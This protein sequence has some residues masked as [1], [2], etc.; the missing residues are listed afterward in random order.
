MRVPVT[1]AF[2]DTDQ[3][4]SLEVTLTSEQIEWLRQTADERDLPV[5]HVLRTILT[6]QMRDEN[7]TA[8]P[9]S[10][11]GDSI[12]HSPDKHPTPSS[13]EAERSATDD[14]PET[15]ESSSNES[16]SEDDSPSIVE[17]L[18]SAS[19]RLQ[20]LTE[21]EDDAKEP[22]RHDTLA[23]LRAHAENAQDAEND[24]T[25]ND[26]ETVLMDDAPSRSMFDMMED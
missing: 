6:A 8:A 24:A 13:A 1:D 22:D 25:E 21:D 20:D 10:E 15:D 12:P 23:R 3:L 14:V 26:P 2:D 18:R 7:E 5:D 4:E 11:S 16:S 19:E 9:P 17:S